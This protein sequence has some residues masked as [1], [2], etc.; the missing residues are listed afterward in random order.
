MPRMTIGDYGSINE[1]GTYIPG[2][3]GNGG[4]DLRILDRNRNLQSS[5]DFALD[6]IH[7]LMHTAR[8]GHPFDITNA[9]DC[10]LTK[11]GDGRSFSTTSNT[12]PNIHDNLMLYNINNLNGV[13]LFERWQVKQGD[14]LT[15]GQLNYLKNQVKMQM[16]GKGSKG[17]NDADYWSIEKTGESLETENE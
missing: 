5:K 11:C 7:E 16:G 4:S 6:F 17:E 15:P 8:I 9:L 1:V 10:E 3:E 14:R 12:D 13:S 2:M